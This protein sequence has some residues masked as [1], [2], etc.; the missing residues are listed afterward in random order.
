MDF[1]QAAG[2]RHDVAGLAEGHPPPWLTRENL[3][4]V[5]LAE[6][7]PFSEEEYAGRMAEV[8]RRMAERKVHAAVVFRPSS[9]EY[10][11]GYHTAET[12][13]QPLLVT[14]S[15]SVLYV[16]DFEVGRAAASS[17]LRKV[18]HF[19]YASAHHALASIA[20]HIVGTVPARARIA[21]ESGG[22]STPP[23]MI[24]LLR[25]EGLEVIDGR[26]LVEGVRLVLSP[27]ELRHVERA[28]VATQAGVDAAIEAAT[29]PG[30]TDS[31]VAA[32]IA[33]ALFADANSASAW[34]PTV[35]T[36]ARAG[37][38]HSTWTGVPLSEDA[39]F[40]EFSG[41]HHRYHAPVMRTICRRPPSAVIRRLEQLSKTAVAAVLDTVRAGI[42]CS[43]VARAALAA[44]GPLPED[45]IF[46]HLFG[47]PVGLAHPPHWMDGAPFS[48]TLDNP[49]PLREG[50]VFHL[51]GSFR[52]LGEAGVGLSHTFVVSKTGAR[53]LTHGTAEL[54]EL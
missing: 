4:S 30:A 21:A 27:A 23:A 42:P 2:P 48:I 1:G 5:D 15:D 7:L 34:G 26:H 8:R 22:P 6:A 13:P 52:V 25:T 14:D 47:Y 12:I 45:V 3:A 43:D 44:L 37:I 19:S 41:A 28:A 51:P 9:V 10:L 40:L 24:D 20:L 39:T 33:A 16:P 32:A 50:M 49:E 31:S 35:A 29:E 18:R 11:C 38:P 17:C 46:H 36:G 54:I 53:V